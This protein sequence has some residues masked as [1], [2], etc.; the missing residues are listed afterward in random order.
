MPIAMWNTI[1]LHSSEFHLTD[2][3]ARPGRCGQGV[4][5][6]ALDAEISLTLTE[7]VY[8]GLVDGRQS[9]LSSH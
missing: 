8:D 9:D 1:R 7:V 3:P 6:R 2:F 5:E 4:V